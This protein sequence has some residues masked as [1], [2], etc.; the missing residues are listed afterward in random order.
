VLFKLLSPTTIYY[1]FFGM[2][3]EL[4]PEIPAR[5]TQIDYDLEIA[6]VALDEDMDEN[7]Q[8]D[9]ML[10]VARIIG[11]PDGKMGEF[12]VLAG[13]TWQGTGIG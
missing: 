11:A 3:K 6:L 2:L 8:T 4:K 13:D 10:G 5:F 12:A 7:S 9:S 1:R